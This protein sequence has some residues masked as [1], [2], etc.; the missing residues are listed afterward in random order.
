MKEDTNCPT[1]LIETSKARTL[2]VH[3]LIDG[4]FEDPP[5][6]VPLLE[7][8]NLTVDDVW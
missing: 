1:Q 3:D 2:Q 5:Q 8:S 7:R 4:M 6:T